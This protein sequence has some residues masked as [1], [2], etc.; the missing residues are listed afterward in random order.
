MDNA[1]KYS[2]LIVD[3]EAQNIMEL[4]H[5]LQSDYTIYVA[6]T[7]AAAI[8]AAKKHLP[9]LILLD[10]I[11]PEMSGYA[12][13]A[14]LKE[15]E[16]TKNIP[17]IFITRLSDSGDAERGLALGAVDYITKPFPHTLVKLRVANQIALIEQLRQNEYDIMKYKLSNDALNIALWDMDVVSGD[18]INPGNRFTWSREFREM[19]GFSDEDDFPNVLQSWSDQLHPEDKKE[20]LSAFMA[21]MNDYSGRTPYDVE[22]R[23][24]LKNGEY[25]HFH[26]LGTTFRDNAGIPVRVAG[27]LMDITEK[28]RM[29]REI[30]DSIA[31][32]ESDAHW[33]KSIL[34]AISLPI[35]VTD[36]DMKWTFVNKAVEDFLGVK[37]EDIYGTPCSNWDSEIC[38]TDNCGIACAK[39]GLKHTYFSRKDSYYQVDVEILRDMEDKIAGFIEVVQ[40]ITDIQE[41]ARQRAEI[42]MTSHAKSAFLANMSHEIRT[43]MNAI[44]GITEILMQ[45][46]TLP[47]ETMEGLGRIHSSCGLLIGIIN[48]I[49]DFSKIEAGKMDIMPAQYNV[50]SLLNDSIHLN[51][52]R[53]GDKPIE[54]DIQ[55]DENILSKLIG[56]ELRIK[57]ILNNLL[58]NAFKYTDTGKVTL[59]AAFEPSKHGVTLILSVRDT[60]RGMTAEQ[61]ERLFEE[62]SRFNQ[63]GGPSIEGT[64]LGLSIT[65]RL[66]ALMGGEI[67]V[68]SEPGK[69]SVFT[70]RLPQGTVDADVLGGELADELRQFRLRYMTSGQRTKIIRE[71][72]PYGNVLIVD[73]VE[74]NL[75]VSQGLMKP[76]GLKIDTAMS[77]PEAIDKI[78]SGNV[79]DIVFMDHMMPVMDGIETTRLL[80]GLGYASPIVALTA[81]AVIGQSDIFLQN[82]FDAF[83]SKPIDIRHLNSI[84][85]KLI[86]DKQPPEVKEAARR[87]MPE[88]NA[89]GGQ[90]QV[91]S[92][93]LGSFI[94]DANKAMA[95]LEELRQ[96]AGFESE[97]AL[98]AFTITVHGIKSALAN[99]GESALSETAVTLE[100]AGREQNTEVIMALTPGF[101]QDLRVL[102]EKIKPKQHP[103]GIAGDITGL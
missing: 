60:G 96:K 42:E 58:S 9:D 11:M 32:I 38:N 45:D 90:Q 12:V 24:K 76:Y 95:V 97:E 103:G 47:V 34:D 86:R 99:I 33:Y 51:M 1:K 70:V 71:P 66:V 73:D 25:R 82:G 88:V 93:L 61:V 6:K 77:G 79:Y 22:Y 20:T 28:K 39:R 35:T 98:R 46:G 23:L 68:D 84:L 72:M 94:R 27:A 62:Y 43:P 55:I 26:A 10:V 2:V 78:K 52:M 87:S 29:E 85:N 81:N 17:I 75:Y 89:C 36:A 54:F 59:S 92:L 101:I 8:K 64:G 5:I 102:I 80:R 65:Q 7:G 53:I 63:E 37:R 48:D 13:I 91:N 100:A 15:F 18:P 56:D 40:D 67:Y 4:T 3:D 74:T 19:L 31:K 21:H 16:Q 49:L 41:L 50:A 69:G 44:W 30:A 83:I 14:E 57:Q